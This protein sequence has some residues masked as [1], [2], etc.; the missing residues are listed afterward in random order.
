[1]ITDLESLIKWHEKKLDHGG[2][3]GDGTHDRAMRND[4]NRPHEEAIALLKSLQQPPK[5]TVLRLGIGEVVVG[6]GVTAAGNRFLS[7]ELAEGLQVGKR[8]KPTEKPGTVAV[9][10]EE[11]KKPGFVILREEIDVLLRPAKGIVA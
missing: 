5:P 6:R 9:V 10:I 8:M 4:A 2:S 3:C 1:M 11:I 7:F